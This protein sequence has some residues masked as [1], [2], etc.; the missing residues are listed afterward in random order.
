MP[1]DLQLHTSVK[2]NPLLDERPIAPATSHNKFVQRLKA[3][4]S[5]LIKFVTYFILVPVA[6]PFVFLINIIYKKQIISFFDGY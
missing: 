3:L 2:L 5:L 4:F 6:V 1:A